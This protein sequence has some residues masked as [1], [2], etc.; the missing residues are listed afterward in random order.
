LTM[1]KG[2]AGLGFLGVRLIQAPSAPERD[3]R[4]LLCA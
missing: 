4:G 3:S 2:S 1:A